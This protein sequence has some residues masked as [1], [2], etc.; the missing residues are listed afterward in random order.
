MDLLAR[1]Q[2]K[3]FCMDFD[4]SISEVQPQS[5]VFQV[6]VG[7]VASKNVAFQFNGIKRAAETRDSLT[8]NLQ[9][10]TLRRL[11]AAVEEH[12]QRNRRSSLCINRKG[13]AQQISVVPTERGDRL[14]HERQRWR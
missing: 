10:I 3:Y 2:A 4:T 13:N 11:V 7:D 12:A 8:L 9:L 1:G 14:T 5:S 6:T